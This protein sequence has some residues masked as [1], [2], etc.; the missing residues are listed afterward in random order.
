MIRQRMIILLPV[1]REC[2]F[3]LSDQLSEDNSLIVRGENSI[4]PLNVVTALGPGR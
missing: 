4:F 2:A 3:G 1:R